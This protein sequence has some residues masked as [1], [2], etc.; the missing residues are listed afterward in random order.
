MQIERSV[1]DRPFFM[2]S[3]GASNPIVK[4]HKEYYTLGVDLAS[5]C[6]KGAKSKHPDHRG[7][8]ISFEQLK[9]KKI[10]Q[11]YLKNARQYVGKSFWSFDL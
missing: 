8:E 2:L 1:Y 7:P 3:F 9:I 4:T 10:I 5:A 6:N 11:V